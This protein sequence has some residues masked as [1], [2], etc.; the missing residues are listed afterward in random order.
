MTF[1]ASTGSRIG[2]FTRSPV[3]GWAVITGLV[4]WAAFVLWRTGMLN[5][6]LEEDPSR[7]SIVILL[8]YTASQIHALRVAL[9]LHHDRSL[10]ARYGVTLARGGEID[11]IPDSAILEF[12]ATRR[13]HRPE[14]GREDSFAYL[15]A[16]LGD[17]LN[18][19]WFI[20]D[21]LFKLGLIGTVIGFIL[22]LGSITDLR[23]MD[24]QQAQ[25]ML[26]DMSAGMRLAL[27]T[28]LTGLSCG[29]LVGIQ[30]HLLERSADSLARRIGRL[31]ESAGQASAP[32]T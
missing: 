29:A 13:A 19:G 17:R 2:T 10:V 3:L 21:L 6:L 9:S 25:S 32:R 7:I 28:T 27:Y 4:V 22:M 16:L 1:P 24:I 14:S 11:P 5:R 31:L 26:G 23:S 20:A 15:H 12:I 18:S 8:G 30:F